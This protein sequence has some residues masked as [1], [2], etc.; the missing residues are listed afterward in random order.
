MKK[1]CVIL[2]FTILA[3]FLSACSCTNKKY[4]P[5]DVL[6]EWAYCGQIDAPGA[7]MSIYYDTKTKVMY[8]RSGN[9]YTVLLNADGTPMLYEESK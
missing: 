5:S 3:L 7:N 6:C 4:E 1:Y 9:G 8:A 2:I